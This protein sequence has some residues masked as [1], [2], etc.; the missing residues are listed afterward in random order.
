MPS[1]LEWI[2]MVFATWRVAHLIAHEDGPFGVIAKLRL[3]AG[4]SE[5]G[6][7]MDCSY[8]LGLWIAATVMLWPS[9]HGW[10]VILV[11][12]SVSGGACLLERV[13]EKK[14]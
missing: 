2:L 12:L 9:L 7:L 13:T 5:W 1:F 11:W 6:R 10:R 4:N 3:R 14:F 8:C